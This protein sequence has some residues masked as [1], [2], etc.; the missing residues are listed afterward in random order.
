MVTDKINAILIKTKIWEQVMRKFG[1]IASGVLVGSSLMI[2]TSAI[3]GGFAIR[4]QST[5]GLGLAFADA[6]AGSDLSSMFW[7]PAAVTA[8]DGMNTVSSSPAL[9]I[10]GRPSWPRKPV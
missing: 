3:A 4:E 9:R 7:N 8:V 1:Y 5:T 6:A 10:C 2:A